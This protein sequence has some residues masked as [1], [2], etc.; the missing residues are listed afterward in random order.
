MTTQIDSGMSHSPQA[1]A[2]GGSLVERRLATAE[3]IAALAV[4]LTLDGAAV[5]TGAIPII[6]GR[7]TP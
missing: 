5:T 3:E 2:A 7:F 6:G 1:G 4:A